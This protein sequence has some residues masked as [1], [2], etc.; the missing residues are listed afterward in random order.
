ML[1]ARMMLSRVDPLEGGF[2]QREF[3]CV[4]CGQEKSVLVRFR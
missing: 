1:R 2:D 3:E 4:H